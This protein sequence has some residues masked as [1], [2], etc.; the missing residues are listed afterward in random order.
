VQ[1]SSAIIA[2]AISRG[3]LHGAELTGHFAQHQFI[4]ADV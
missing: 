2:R 3:R 1:R 4:A